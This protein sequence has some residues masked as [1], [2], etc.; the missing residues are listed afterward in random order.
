MTPT[1]DKACQC[2]CSKRAVY[3]QPKSKRKVIIIAIIVAAILLILSI[4]IPV[5]FAV[6]KPSNKDSSDGLSSDST[7]GGSGGGGK[8]RVAA[9]TG[10]GSE[11]TLE[12]LFPE[13]R[14]VGTILGE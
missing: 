3:A 7:S 2:G 12:N 5:Y 13:V 14:M 11:V 10:D 1:M 9:V 6:V 4:A 8:G